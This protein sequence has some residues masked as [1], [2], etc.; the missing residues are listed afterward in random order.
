MSTLKKNLHSSDCAT[1]ICN[2]TLVECA[3]NGGIQFEGDSD[4]GGLGKEQGK[5]RTVVDMNTH[6]I[7]TFYIGK[8]YDVRIQSGFLINPN[9]CKAIGKCSYYCTCRVERVEFQEHE[10]MRSLGRTTGR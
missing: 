4:G 10:A 7:Y 5:S 2:H 9:P 1:N 6:F 8:M 3:C